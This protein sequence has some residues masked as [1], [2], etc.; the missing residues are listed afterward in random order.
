MGNNIA[1][2]VTQKCKEIARPGFGL[3]AKRSLW[4]LWFLLQIEHDPA[5]RWVW[6]SQQSTP[7]PGSTLEECHHQLWHQS[8]ALL[9]SQRVVFKAQHVFRT[10]YLLGPSPLTWAALVSSTEI[11]FP[12]VQSSIYCGICMRNLEYHWKAATF[13]IPAFVQSL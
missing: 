10:K 5:G 3:S 1:W 11:G 2:V 8:L 9:G 7:F 4:Q 13:E 12:L 6:C